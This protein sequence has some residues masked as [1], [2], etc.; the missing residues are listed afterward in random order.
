MSNSRYHYH[1]KKP[2]AT[3]EEGARYYYNNDIYNCLGFTTVKM[4]HNQIKL[5][6]T[7]LEHY[8]FL[9]YNCLGTA[10]ENRKA[11]DEIFFTYHILLNI[12]ACYRKDHNMLNISQIELS[13]DFKYHIA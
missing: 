9:L 10:P 2:V 8:S 12:Y 7:A 1:K 5:V 3:V 11:I 6:M 4:H 13:D